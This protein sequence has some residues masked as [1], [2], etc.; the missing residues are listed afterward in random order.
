MTAS[1]EYSIKKSLFY[2]LAAILLCRCEFVNAQAD[3]SFG[4][5]LKYV[6]PK[7]CPNDP[8]TI[9]YTNTTVMQY[10]MMIYAQSTPDLKYVL[11]PH[12]VF[13]MGSP[14]DGVE[15]LEFPIS[16][17]VSNTEILCGSDGKLVNNCTLVGGVTQIY[18]V[19]YLV[20]ENITFSGLTMTKNE[21]VTIYAHGNWLSSAIFKECLIVENK[22]LI[23]VHQYFD[24]DLTDNDRKLKTN[25]PVIDDPF[26]NTDIVHRGLHD[27]FF[28]YLDQVRS[29][30]SS[31]Y[32]HSLPNARKIRRNLQEQAQVYP[33]MHIIF[34]ATDIR[35]N[36]MQHGLINI[37]SITELIDCDVSYNNVGFATIS[38]LFGGELVLEQSSFAKNSVNTRN[39]VKFGP[40]FVDQYSAIEVIDITVEGSNGGGCDIFFEAANSKCIL[41]DSSECDGR[42]CDF[43][44]TSCI[45]GGTDEDAPMAF[46]QGTTKDTSKEMA[47]RLSPIEGG[48]INKEQVAALEASSDGKGNTS[49]G[50][51]CISLSVIFSLAAALCIAA[52]GWKIYRSRLVDETPDTPLDAT[53]NDDAVGA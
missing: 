7:V 42:C 38:T 22:G 11:C 23:L 18:F 10:D 35:D 9:G 40:V 12:T 30:T 45:K 29:T 44:S 27:N 52:F 31:L 2:T 21:G 28:A 15:Q 49:C 6:G 34:F 48:S 4:T 46:E 33:G 37:N 16:P 8:N 3:A 43:T 17:L 5:M 20:V 47:E 19:D 13:D 53:R 50:A 14:A 41:L 1:V 26:I 51:L 24:G 32:Q 25:V 39:S 36:T